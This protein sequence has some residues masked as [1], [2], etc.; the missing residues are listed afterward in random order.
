MWLPGPCLGGQ[1]PRWPGVPVAM[2]CTRHLSRSGQKH[3]ESSATKASVRPLIDV[4]VAVLATKGSAKKPIWLK[5]QYSESS[6]LL[7]FRRGFITQ[8]GSRASAMCT[9]AAAEYPWPC[10]GE[11]PEGKRLS[12]AGVGVQE[13]LHVGSRSAAPLLQLLGNS[14]P[15]SCSSHRERFYCTRG[16]AR[17]HAAAACASFVVGPLCLLH[18]WHASM[19]WSGTPASPLACQNTRLEV[20]LRERM[21]SLAF[22]AAVLQ[23]PSISV[24]IDRQL[25]RALQTHLCEQYESYTTPAEMK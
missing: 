5:T 2:P 1:R 12:R 3:T 7:M 13:G 11:W 25:V 19:R 6:F 16:T 9:S 23:A 20:G 18:L 4:M 21:Q 22:A 10:T 24:L 17:Q 8:T 14:K 15:F